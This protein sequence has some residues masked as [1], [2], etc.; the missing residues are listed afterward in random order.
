MMES[1]NPTLI[2]AALV[3][4]S[5]AA[6]PR[7]YWYVQLPAALGWVLVWFDGEFTGHWTDS[8]GL[9]VTGVSMLWLWFV[10]PPKDTKQRDRSES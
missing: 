9:A 7:R 5:F 8:L 4:L 10:K 1:L 3:L 2:W 6:I